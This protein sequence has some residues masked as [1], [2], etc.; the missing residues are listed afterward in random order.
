[1]L[2]LPFFLVCL[3]LGFVGGDKPYAVLPKGPREGG[4]GVFQGRQ[5]EIHIK[6]SF[7]LVCLQSGFAGSVE[8][9]FPL[10]YLYLIS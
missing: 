6:A 3:Q 8:R 10:C 4:A 1:M 9:N 7:F 5:I 2:P